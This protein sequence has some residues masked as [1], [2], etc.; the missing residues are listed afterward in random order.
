MGL[1]Y[2]CD[3]PSSRER[4]VTHFWW[5]PITQLDSEIVKK[6]EWLTLTRLKMRKAPRNQRISS[7]MKIFVTADAL[8]QHGTWALGQIQIG[9]LNYSKA[10]QEKNAIQSWLQYLAAAREGEGRRRMFYFLRWECNQ[11][12]RERRNLVAFLACVL[13][14]R[15]HGRAFTIVNAIYFCKQPVRTLHYL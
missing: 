8:Y 2:I 15:A 6:K 9:D 7:T 14:K 10:R 12:S 3:S 13:L 1:V 5:I 11:L 4:A